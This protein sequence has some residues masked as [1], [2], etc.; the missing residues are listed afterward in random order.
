[1]YQELIENYEDMPMIEHLH[2]G[3]YDSIKDDVIKPEIKRLEYTEN[4]LLT[5]DD[6]YFYNCRI[7]YISSGN[8]ESDCHIRRTYEEVLN[9][10]TKEIEEDNDIAEFKIMKKSF[11][12]N[13]EATAEFI[14]KDKQPI[15]IDIY[16]SDDSDPDISTIFLNMPTPFKK[17]D[18]LCSNSNV[19]FWN[20]YIPRNNNVFVLDWLITWDSN[21]EKRLAKGN[22]D[23]S[24]MGGN[25]YFIDDNRVIFEHCFDYDSW[26]YFEGTLTAM[27]RILKG[28]QSLLKDEISID[29][30]LEAYD[31]MK[32]EQEKNCLDWFTD[33]GLK[34]AGF[35]E[36]D[37][38]RMKKKE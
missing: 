28:I 35:S 32:R 8:Y 37:I 11:T 10:I 29:L 31:E 22:C 7:C 6:D 25:G 20:G 24:D 4:K 9:D 33:E 23:D 3:P 30:F 15:M 16:D 13:Y 14:V 21:L 34:L 26:E 1:M 2:C 38:Q 17:G 27:E 5:K 19:P 36:R 12:T 18:L